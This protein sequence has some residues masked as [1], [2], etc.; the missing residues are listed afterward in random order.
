MQGRMIG[1]IPR[2]P[3]VPPL[4]MIPPPPGSVNP[5]V[6]S[7]A[8]QLITRQQPMESTSKKIGATIEAKPQIRLL[9]QKSNLTPYSCLFLCSCRNLSADITR[10]MPM[11]VRARKD[12]K[13]SSKK[14]D[15]RAE[16]NS[17]LRAQQ[18]AAAA[19]QAQAASQNKDDAYMQFMN[20][21]SSLL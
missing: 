5:N 16:A 6:L 7:A 21:M 3:G 19:I 8:P 11:S 12:E 9:S 14:P 10:F 2:P 20:E 13:P 15:I 1:N 18:Q 4:G 17:Y